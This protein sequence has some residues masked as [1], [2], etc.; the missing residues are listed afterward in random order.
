M[1]QECVRTSDS[2]CRFGG[3]EFVVLV[4]P[5]HDATDAVTVAGRILAALA[6]PFLLGGHRIKTTASIGIALNPEDGSDATTLLK[7]ADIAMY[8][9]KRGGGNRFEF[10]SALAEE[11]L[12]AA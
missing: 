7:N 11:A 9:A 10:F 4:E 12:T 2:V 5:M 1:L 3:D 6:P 8:K